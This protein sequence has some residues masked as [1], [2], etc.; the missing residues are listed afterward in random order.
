MAIADV[1]PENALDFSELDEGAPPATDEGPLTGTRGTRGRAPRTTRT[2][3]AD[4]EETAPR[5]R[6]PS[7]KRLESLVDKLSEQMFM[8]GA[9]TSLALPVTGTY[10]CQESHT[11]PKAV[12][13]LAATRPEWITALEKLS[14]LQPGLIVAR[15]ALGVGGALAVDRG[16]AKPDSRIMMVLGVH[17]A[18]IDYMTG[19]EASASEGGSYTPPP[20]Q[21]VPVG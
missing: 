9:A 2:P 13:D 3:K 10:I 19:E 8:A 12:V 21:F 20:A 18:Y 17:Q 5:P 7:A 16:R 14:M 1:L 4:G 15:T 6:R 11:F